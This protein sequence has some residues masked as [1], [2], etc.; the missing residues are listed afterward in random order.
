MR[1]SG[2]GDISGV[3][4]VPWRGGGEERARERER[5]RERQRQAS[6]NLFNTLQAHSS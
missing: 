3:R 4:R 6:T 1:E 5:E 2:E